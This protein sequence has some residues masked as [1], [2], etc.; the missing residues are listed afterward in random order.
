MSDGRLSVIFV[1]P[2]RGLRARRE[3]GFTLFELIVVIVIFSIMVGY[4]LNKAF[5][6]LEI[7]EKA[8]METQRLMMR[9]GM[10]LQIAG[11]ITSGRE[12]EVAHLVGNNPID[13]LREKPQ[14]YLGAFPAEPPQA[15]ESGGWYFDTSAREI[16][17]VAKR[18]TFLKPDSSGRFRVRYQ[19]AVGSPADG[20]QSASLWLVL[21]PVE[22]YKWF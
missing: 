13:W 20:K 17:Y 22:P 15:A 4:L 18:H 5:D 11:L 3:C 2:Q 16:V 9:S 6:N 8:A 1:T 19:V 10:D 21:S 12:S 7:A 14:N